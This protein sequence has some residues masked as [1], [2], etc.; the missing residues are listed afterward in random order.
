MDGRAEFIG[1]K[2]TVTEHTDPSICGISGIIV[3]ET[4]ETITINC[5]GNRKM[6][7]KRPATL[8]FDNGEIMGNKIA[9]RPQ[10]RIKKVKA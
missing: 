3:D 8:S 1:E 2:V 9:Y 6:V 10:D 4:R 7:S 5:N